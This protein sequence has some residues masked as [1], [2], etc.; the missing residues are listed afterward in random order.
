MS[1]E[2]RHGENALFDGRPGPKCR[3]GVVRVTAGVTRIKFS[4]VKALS[5]RM[6][7]SVKD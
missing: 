1:L 2:V 7:Q 6:P 4:R 3:E 5:H